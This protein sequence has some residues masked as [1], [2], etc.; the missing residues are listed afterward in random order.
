[1]DLLERMIREAEAS[2]PRVRKAATFNEIRKYNHNHGPDG[3]FS[4]S[5]GS[6]GSSPMDKIRSN[7][8]GQSDDMLL[9]TWK[10]TKDSTDTASIAVNSVLE[11]ELEERGLIK[12]NDDTF[13]YEI[14]SKPK[15]APKKTPAAPTNKDNRGNELTKEQAEYFKNSKARDED[16]N[17]MTLY[18]ATDRE[19]VD[20]FYTSRNG[21]G[22]FYMSDTKGVADGYGYKQTYTLYA[23]LE[24]PLTIDAGGKAYDSIEPP[25]GMGRKYTFGSKSVDTQAIAA[26]ARDSGYDGVIVHNVKEPTGTGTDVIAFNPNQIKAVDNEAPTSSDKIAKF[27]QNHG[28]D[29]RFAESPG[30]GGGTSSSGKY[31]QDEKVKAIEDWSDGGYGYVRKAQR[32]QIADPKRVKQAEAIEE[33]IAEQPDYGGVI[34]RGVSK[35]KPVTFKRGQ[36]LDMNGVSSWSSDEEVAQLFAGGENSRGE[37]HKYIFNAFS[38]SGSADIHSIAMN[39]GEREVLVS[40]NT[41]FVVMDVEDRKITIPDTGETTTVTY[42]TVQSM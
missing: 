41:K 26:Y 8:K 25:E 36:T 39:P 29:G 11:T 33:Y 31:S 34:Y 23:N 30:T 13:E 24:N 35:E 7:I 18:H 14:V 27:N 37:D 28:P 15:K 5:P 12:L 6:G 20:E 38:V 16:G 40:Q 9:S 17:L 19:N 10:Q 3:K 2:K 1:M 4:E 22:G 21:Y 32:G 42:V